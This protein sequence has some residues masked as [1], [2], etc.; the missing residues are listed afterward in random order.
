MP[1]LPPAL[2]NFGRLAWDAAS[3]LNVQV[4]KGEVP[5]NV[6]SDEVRAVGR[7]IKSKIG[8][9]GMGVS[10]P[11]LFEL[12]VQ[13]IEGLQRRLNDTSAEGPAFR[14][15]DWIGNTK[16]KA[17]AARNATYSAFTH[18]REAISDARRVL[19]P[20]NTDPQPTPKPEPQ[21][22][23]KPT[24]KPDPQPKP[25]PKPDPQ[26]KP[27]PKPDP[28]PKPTPKPDPQPKPT[29][30]PPDE[31]PAKSGMSLGKILIIGVLA[32]A[33]GKAAKLF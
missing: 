30:K 5:L 16:N 28:Q 17:I 14:D 3:A 4:K 26:P 29:P 24:P 13:N 33:A 21:P 32:Y 23:P 6:F 22:Q 12:I 18:A 1:D 31:T 9:D 19:P 7:E 15:P 11:F 2:M 10:S 20:L 8:T 27:T 25:T